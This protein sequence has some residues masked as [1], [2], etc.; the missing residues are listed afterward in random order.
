MLCRIVVKKISELEVGAFAGD[1]IVRVDRIIRVQ[2]VLHPLG[3]HRSMTEQEGVHIVVFDDSVCP[4]FLCFFSVNA[5]WL[6]Q[7][8]SLLSCP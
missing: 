3:P 8:D 5:F 7:S 4:F 2:H 1:I 6:I